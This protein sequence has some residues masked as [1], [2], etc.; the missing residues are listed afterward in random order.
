MLFIA[1]WEGIHLR[2][3]EKA[4]HAITPGEA[5]V[6]DA[7]MTVGDEFRLLMMMVLCFEVHI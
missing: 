1:I 3:V 6:A 4:L 5:L 7:Q 2:V